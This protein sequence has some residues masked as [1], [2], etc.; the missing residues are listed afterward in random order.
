MAD[1]YSDK[2]RLILQVSG[3]N[4]GTWGDKTDTNIG[5]LLEEAIAGVVTVEMLSDANYTLVASDG[6]SDEARNAVV[7]V[8]SGVSLTTTRD[9]IVPTKEKLYLVY[10]NT[11]GAQ[12]IRVKTSAGSGIT[13]PVGKK[14]YVYCDGTNVVDAITNLPSGSTIGG[15]SPYFAGGT[16]IPLADGGTATSLTAPGADRIFFWD[17]SGLAANWLELGTGLSITATTMSL[18]ANLQTWSGVAPS[19]N[20]QS[21]VAAADY[22]AM[23]ALLDL[24]AGTDF[25]SPAA[26]AAAYQPLDAQLTAFAANTAITGT[27]TVSTSDPSG[28]ADGDVH[29]KYTA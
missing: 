10:N 14:Q 25:L 22:A 17:H 18:S 11:T 21:L 27:F 16:D 24:E 15:S 6:S 26:I 1:S 5:T 4:D 19:A 20:G 12:S 28:G 23:R 13:I 3:E 7:Q 2:L 8:T 9:I 29:L